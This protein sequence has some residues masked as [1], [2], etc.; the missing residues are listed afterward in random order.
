MV[1]VPGSAS[2]ATAARIAIQ[3]SEDNKHV[4]HNTF[5]ELFEQIA[6]KKLDKQDEKGVFTDIQI[7]LMTGEQLSEKEF[8]V[9]EKLSTQIPP[10][11]IQNAVDDGVISQQDADLL[12]M[13]GGL[14]ANGV[15]SQADI[16]KGLAN[17]FSLAPHD[18]DFAR[19]VMMDRPSGKHDLQHPFLLFG[20]LRDA[21]SAD[22]PEQA[23]M[24]FFLQ[25]MEPGQ[26]GHI[27][28]FTTWNFDTGHNAMAAA[29]GDIPDYNDMSKT[30][31]NA[32]THF[33]QDLGNGFSPVKHHGHHHHG[34]AGGP[35]HGRP[36][37]HPGHYPGFGENCQFGPNNMM[38]PDFVDGLGFAEQGK[39][40][41]GSLMFQVMADRVESLDNQVREFA[42][43][44]DQQN[45]QLSTNTNAMAALRANLPEDG[46]TVDL[47]NVT[48]EDGD[49][50][51]VSLAGYLNEEGLIK[52][53]AN[54]GHMSD[55]DIDNMLSSINGKNDVLNSES[56]ATM[57]K[58]Q[59][60][61][62]KYQQAVQVQTN[63]EAKWNTML[64]AI[65]GNL[66][67]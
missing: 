1:Y 44:V 66:S 59:Q 52:D 21:H 54:L 56:T 60:T 62:D 14:F 65:I 32:M 13:A 9:L 23:R 24:A 67:R 40:D 45:K 26:Q 6:N 42:D 18:R 41:L 30:Q 25:N 46:G 11:L 39:I 61:M 33:L 37:H 47:S 55:T 51:T 53:G 64:N 36:A 17:F 20:K 22:N 7:K 29:L 48:F 10:H 28:N 58:L 50:N 34:P 8:K 16:E 43:M 12:I 15:D 38:G 2:G 49:G 27:Q 31:Q 5:N 63:F 4:K 19:D 3:N 35:E 57:T